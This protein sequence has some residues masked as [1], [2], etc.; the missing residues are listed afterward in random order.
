LLDNV[1]EHISKPTLLFNEIK[2]V[3]RPGGIILIGVPGI[4][5]FKNDSDHKIFY[6]EMK[7][8]NLAKKFN[9]SV[10]CIFYTPFFRSIFLS[11]GLKQYCIYTQWKK[12]IE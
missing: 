3:L 9:F 11:K 7:L 4:R 2:R 12:E 6:D 5:G 1:L 10:K 8:K